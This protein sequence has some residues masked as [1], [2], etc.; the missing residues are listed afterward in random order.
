MLLMGLAACGSDQTCRCGYGRAADGLCY[1][2]ENPDGT[3]ACQP[4]D[5][6]DTAD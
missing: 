6:G 4:S 2:V 5:T 1:P 3:P